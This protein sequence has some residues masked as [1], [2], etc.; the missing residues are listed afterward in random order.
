MDPLL[1]DVFLQVAAEYS[2]CTILPH[3]PI[4]HQEEVRVQTVEHVQLAQGVQQRL[5]WRDHLNTEDHKPGSRP[6]W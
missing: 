5:I 2:L 6:P 1:A 3:H 4:I